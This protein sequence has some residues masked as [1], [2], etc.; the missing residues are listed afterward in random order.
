LFEKICGIQ[1]TN[2][3]ILRSIIGP[4]FEVSLLDPKVLDTLLD[5]LLD[6]TIIEGYSFFSSFFLFFSF[7][8]LFQKKKKKN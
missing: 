1:D 6:R 2:N 5:H 3:P 8:F 7:F 4:L